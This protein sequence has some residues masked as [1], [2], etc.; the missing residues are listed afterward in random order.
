M[1]LEEILVSEIVD[2]TSLKS[3]FA[4]DKIMLT[5]IIEVFLSDTT[6]KIAILEKNIFKHNYKDLIDI[7]NF[8]KPSFGL[9]GINCIN[10]ITDLEQLSKNDE[11][12]IIIKE[13]LNQVVLTSK[14]SLT[15][16]KT[17]LDKLKSL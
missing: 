7:C 11:S 15:E 4:S 2:L 10:E 6:P 13:K 9:M 16:Y 5:Q 1:K 8:L 14:E 12:D 17:I 3:F